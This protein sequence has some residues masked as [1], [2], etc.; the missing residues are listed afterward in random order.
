MT[1][2]CQLLCHLTLRLLDAPSLVCL[3]SA[4]VYVNMIEQN[5]N[6][7]E[8][9]YDSIKLDCH[10]EAVLVMDPS[11]RSSNR[12]TGLVWDLGIAPNSM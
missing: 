11:F 3:D 7:I 12:G 4:P 6:L 8:L 9:Y 1:R 5:S 2:I 10:S